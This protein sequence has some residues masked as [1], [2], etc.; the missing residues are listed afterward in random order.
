VLHGE[1]LDLDLDLPRLGWLRGS[2]DSEDESR[3]W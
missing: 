3:R 1:L 2:S